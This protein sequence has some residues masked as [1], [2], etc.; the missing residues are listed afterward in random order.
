[1]SYQHRFTDKSNCEYPIGKVVCVGRN[2]ADHA[3]ELNNPIPD[4]PILFIKPQTALSA[5]EEAISTPVNRGECHH[6]LE[7]AVLIGEPLTQVSDSQAAMAISGVGLAL[8]LT[9]RE[10]QTSLKEKKHPWERAKAFDGACPVSAFIN[11]KG[12]DLTQLSLELVINDELRQ[13]GTTADMLF[14]VNTL[15]SEISESF[16]LLPGDIVLTGTPAGVGALKPEDKLQARLLDKNGV[17]LLEVES[18]VEG[19]S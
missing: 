4:Q 12:V 10:L 17:L 7:L 5:F 3:K 8:D 19:R 1:M 9:L 16:T 15:I 6:E 13:Q 14:P 18:Q 2:Y 11:P